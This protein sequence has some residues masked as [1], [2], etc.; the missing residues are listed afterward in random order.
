MSLVSYL[1]AFPIACSQVGADP[2]AHQRGAARGAH[3]DDRRDRR[4]HVGVSGRAVRLVGR[5][6]LVVSSD[7]RAAILLVLL[8]APNSRM[9]C[10]RTRART[11]CAGRCT[12]RG[13]RCRSASDGAGGRC[14]CATRAQ[15]R[16]STRTPPKSWRPSA[17][18]QCPAACSPRTASTSSRY[19]TS[20]STLF[21]YLLCVYM[22]M[23]CTVE[24][25]STTVYVL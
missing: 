24:I 10:T 6:V 17:R 8:A 15:A 21:Q 1:Q 23:Y 19:R 7:S 5:L 3:A 13:T 20:P 11:H 22:Y 4:E 25:G 9:Q 16:R 14:S 18:P 2:L 12:S